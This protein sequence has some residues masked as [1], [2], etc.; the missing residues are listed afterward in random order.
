MSSQPNVEIAEA[1]FDRLGTLTNLLPVAWPNKPFTPTAGSGYLRAHFMPAEPFPAAAGEDAENRYIGFVQVDVL[2]PDGEGLKDLLVYADKV[3]AHF[4]RGT[5]ISA[6][7]FPVAIR[8]PPYVMQPA[9]EGAWW[10]VP[11]RIY[12]VADATQP[13]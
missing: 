8:R 2:W 5:V 12:Y 10:V 1:L 11:V 9:K 3:A 13:A 7:S 6:T 4:K